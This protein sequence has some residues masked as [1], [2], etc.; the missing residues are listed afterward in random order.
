M[1]PGRP[2][3]ESNEVRAAALALLKTSER[4]LSIAQRAN[5]RA[6]TH[7]RLRVKGWQLALDPDT[8]KWISETKETFVSGALEQDAVDSEKAAVR[9]EQA[10]RDLSA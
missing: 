8:R 4:V 1:Q 6:I 5:E 10:R 3:R 2:L 9:L 7:L